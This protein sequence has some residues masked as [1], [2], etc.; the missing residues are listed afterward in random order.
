ALAGLVAFYALDAAALRSRTRRRE[1][2]GEDRAGEG[3][4]WVHAA[5][6]GLYNALIG[7]LVVR[8][9]DEGALG[10]VLFTVAIGVHF[11]VADAGLRD[12][13]KHGYD[14][15]VRWVLAA[16]VPAGLVAGALTAASDAALALLLAFLA[17]AVILN[18]IKEEVPGER[19]SRLAPF[20]AG[21]AAYAAVLLAV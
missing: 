2:V 1:S 13:H 7:Y 5:S 20:L 18:T 9:A 17:G 8:R 4:L 10:L 6:Y 15:V 19:R 14:R 3:V 16:A 11:V 21:A 12:H